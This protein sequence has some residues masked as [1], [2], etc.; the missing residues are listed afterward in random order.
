VFIGEGPSGSADG[1]ARDARTTTATSLV[2][3]TAARCV[4]ATSSH[5]RSG[6]GADGVTS[7]PLINTDKFDSSFAGLSHGR[8]RSGR[9]RHLDSIPADLLHV[10]QR[11][12]HL[13]L[14]FGRPA[15][16]GV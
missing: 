8:A 2:A 1:S 13:A 12:T 9:V 15:Q 10:P 14:S 6:A 5:P 16:Q 7:Q 11:N 3:Q 4:S